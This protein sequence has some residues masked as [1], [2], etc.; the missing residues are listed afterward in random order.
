MSRLSLSK[1][2]LRHLPGVQEPRSSSD[3]SSLTYEPY[4][5]LKEKPFSLAAD[6]KFLF[7]G[8]ASTPAFEDV[9]NGIRRREGLVTLT[10]AVGTGKTALIRSVLQHLDRRAACAFVPDLLVSREDLLKILLVDFGV[11]SVADLK[12]GSLNG[13]SWADLS[14]P[15]YNFFDSLVA[16]QAFAVLIIDQA[17]NLPLP[18]FEEIR[19]LSDLEG[20]ER[21]LQVVLVGQPG[22]RDHLS[23][24]EMQR[25]N[26][27]IS[28]RAQL[29]P[30]ERDDVAGYI[31]H[32]LRAAGS[33]GRTL[34]GPAAIDAVFNASHGTPRL[35]NLICDRA[36]H[37]GFAAGVEQLEPQ[38]IWDAVTDLQLGPND[39]ALSAT[40]HRQT[41]A[42]PSADPMSEF[43][44]E[45]VAEPTHA[46]V[47]PPRR[48][49]SNRTTGPKPVVPAR[50]IRKLDGFSTESARASARVAPVPLRGW[51]SKFTAVLVAVLTAS[52]VL[53]YLGVRTMNETSVPVPPSPM[54]IRPQL[55][56]V[57]PPDSEGLTDP[58][59]VQARAQ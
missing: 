18:V 13:A 38:V 45:T 41:A 56:I 16:Q 10:G 55:P 22:L 53:T 15:L 31:A 42:Q 36:L 9:L 1:R 30:L 19:I 17:Q 59:D 5:G 49:P 52:V 28:V 26:Q 32:R 50:P 6:P 24:P 12:R 3:A 54:P 21:C 2:A 47:R 57:A 23:L 34:F 11:V 4:Y 43:A 37:R 7:R 51:I 58:A 27:R 40:V 25:I 14:Y 39:P 8:P 20:R 48:A 46:A 44:A 29:S 35:I 33:D